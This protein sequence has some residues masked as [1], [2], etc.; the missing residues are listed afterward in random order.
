M[1]NLRKIKDL[2]RK[3]GITISICAKDLG[4]TAGGLQKIIRTNRTKQDTL[5]QIASYFKVP[6]SY[7]SD[8]NETFITNSNDLTLLKKPKV[9][10][11]IELSEEQETKVLKMVLGKDFLKFLNQ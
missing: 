7:F 3:K 6:V 1:I 11:Q 10:I 5:E 8:E 9:I 4:M 2:I